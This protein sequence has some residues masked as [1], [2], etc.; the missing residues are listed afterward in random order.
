MT[1]LVNGQR[2]RCSECN[3]L[4]HPARRFG[5]GSRYF[6]SDVCDDR[7]T[8]RWYDERLQVDPAYFLRGEEGER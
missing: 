2:L 4:L 1:R 8:Y 3:G 6:C 7:F 5:I